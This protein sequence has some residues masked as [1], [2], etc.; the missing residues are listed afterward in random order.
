MEYPA[1]LIA[2]IVR[3]Y[4]NM[5][6]VFGILTCLEIIFVRRGQPIIS[7]ALGLS[8]WMVGI[9]C[10]ALCAWSLSA[11]WAALGIKPL[12]IVE[13]GPELSWAG[14][15]S[16]IAAPL[17]GALIGDFVGYW[18]H[19]IQHRWL[20]PIHAV[21]HSIRDLCAVNSYHH[22][23]DA[24]FTT[25]LVMV[26]TSLIVVDTGPTIAVMALLLWIQPVFLHSPTS[27]TLGPMRHIIADNRYHR[28]HHSLEP[29]HFDKNFGI[30]FSFWDRM[31]GTAYDPHADE[32]PA[33][34][35]A[36]ID[37]PRSLKQWFDLP[38]RVTTTPATPACDS[39]PT[40][41]VGVP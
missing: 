18:Y 8:F 36:E 27:F 32:W 35:L 31:F 28:I 14:P 20:W 3:Q 7:R 21:H 10:M 23:G 39:I 5:V 2:L 11:L 29:Q 17:I 15:V 12:I 34:G 25:L 38:L 13:L 4:L 40:A 16:A 37:E 1:D 22:A 24:I 19:R 33:V 9:P 6:V 30:L 41:P 26:P